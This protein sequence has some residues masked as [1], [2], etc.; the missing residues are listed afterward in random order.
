MAGDLE[1]RDFEPR[2]LRGVLALNVQAMDP[3]ADPME[4]AR[5]RPEL[6]NIPENFQREGAFLVGEVEGEIVA[7]GSVRIESGLSYRVNFV[8]VA[9]ECQRQ[10]FA[11]EMMAALEDRAV[12][13]GAHS[14]VLDTTVEQV[15][16][17]RLY[18]AIGYRETGRDTVTYEAMGASFEIVIYRKDLRKEAAEPRAVELAEWEWALLEECRVAR[19]GTIAKDGRPHVVPVVYAMVDEGI[20]IAIDEKPKATTRLARLRNIE[21]DARVT[22]L[23]DRYDDDWAGL[24]WLR[25]D[26]AAEVLDRGEAHPDALSALRERYPQHRDM[27]LEESPLIVVFPERVVSWRAVGEG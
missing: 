5:I 15:P 17:Q 12:E 3:D 9:I 20:V 27:A 24:A 16:A 18:E 14:I 10:G 21:R 13:L 22:L 4:S 19:L 11:R 23:F 7:M 8:R 25:I 1:I 2:D 26:G 6:L